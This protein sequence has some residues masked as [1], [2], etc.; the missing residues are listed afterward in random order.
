MHETNPDGKKNADESYPYHMPAA[1]VSAAGCII[2]W[3]LHTKFH[4]PKNS[5]SH[6]YRNLGLTRTAQQCIQADSK[7]YLERNAWCPAS[8]FAKVAWVPRSASTRSF[9]QVM[10]ISRSASSFA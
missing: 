5:M 1:F 6:I 9:A 8:C 3:Y 4:N 7:V 10:Q 2:F